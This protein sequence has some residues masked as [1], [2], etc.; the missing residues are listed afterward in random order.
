MVGEYAAEERVQILDRVLAADSQ[1]L[2]PR[3]RGGL[4]RRAV[5]PQFVAIH[6][7]QP[8]VHPQLRYVA[9]FGL[10]HRTLESVRRI[11]VDETQFT[12]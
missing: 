8:D 5:S 12:T 7:L 9:A 2:C 4:E 10:A 3:T 11:G 1:G 6:F